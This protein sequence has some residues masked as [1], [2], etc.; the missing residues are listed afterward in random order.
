MATNAQSFIQPLAQGNSPFTVNNGNPNTVYNQ[1]P[2]GMVN[3]IPQTGAYLAPQSDAMNNWAVNPVPMGGVTTPFWQLPSGGGQPQG[4][5]LTVPPLTV[6]PNWVPTKPPTTPPPTTPPVTPPGGGGGSSAP[7]IGNGGGQGNFGPDL[8]AGGTTGGGGGGKVPNGG[9]AAIGGGLQNLS[10][11]EVLDTLIGGDLYDSASGTW[12]ITNSVAAA[13]NQVFPG[14]GTAAQWAMNNGLL[15]QKLQDFAFNESY[16][17]FEARQARNVQQVSNN[18]SNAM[19]QRAIETAQRR[20]A[21]RA[22]MFN[23]GGAGWNPNFNVGP[24]SN[25]TGGSTNLGSSPF[26]N[27]YTGTINERM[28]NWGAG[29]TQSSGGGR[30]VGGDTIAE[31]NAAISMAEG[32]QR[33]S[34]AAMFASVQQQMRDMIKIQ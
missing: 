23:P 25:I 1:K 7:N 17:Q 12:D 8:W 27:A 18:V 34:N 15:G 28:N 33:A 31:G 16:R 3:F 20:A 19:E 11:Q 29:G 9:F 2:T 13:L 32:L 30:S 10:W 14:L 5:R 26:D 21:E 4:P 22:N 24:V 6:D